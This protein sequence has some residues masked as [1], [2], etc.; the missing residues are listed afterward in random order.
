MK[1]VT[2]KN[3]KVNTEPRIIVT[4]PSPYGEQLCDL[5]AQH[6]IISDHCPLIHFLADRS[7]NTE[8]RLDLLH[9]HHTWIFV[10]RQAVNFCFDSFDAEQKAGIRELANSKVIITV[11]DATANSLAELGFD[12]LIPPTPNSEGM[13]HL[14]EQHQLKEKSTLLI[15]GGQ[16]RKLLQNYFSNGQLNIMPVYHRQPTE[17]PL[18]PL[19]NRTAIVITS[20][21]LLELAASQVTPENRSSCTIIAGSHRISDLAQ[22]MGFTTCYTAKD[23]SNQELAKSCLLWRNNVT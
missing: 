17:K 6:S 4:R 18:P 19:S 7:F 10:S 16:G 21:Q 23:A 1:T 13:I 9:Q 3:S 15:R 8:Q 14:L 20:G 5:L 11:G 12:G 2:T 22:Q